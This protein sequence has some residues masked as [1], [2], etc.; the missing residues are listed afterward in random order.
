MRLKPIL[1]IFIALCI[2]VLG[3]MLPG[4][5]ARRQQR[6]SESQVLFSQIGDVELTFAQSGITCSEAL[7]I[8]SKNKEAVEIPPELASLSREKVESVAASAAEKFRD[9]GMLLS[10]PDEDRLMFAQT[11][12]FY[13]QDNRSN[14]YWIIH[15]G[16]KKNTHT[17]SMVIDDR[18]GT[19]CS[20]EYMD[21]K[22]EYEPEQMEAVLRSFCRLYLTGL[23]EEFFGFSVDALMSNAKSAQ[24]SSYLA[25]EL[26]WENDAY[27]EN[28]VTFF[29]NR[30]GF[31]TYF[32]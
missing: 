32:G 31:Y 27:G 1:A 11:L 10:S 15:Y 4:L 5:I 6:Q 23:G 19:I 25:T 13:G 28:R 2:I 3:A 16:D 7:S 20:V 30:S 29:V 9:G 26:I 18:T 14:I 17:I 22:S 24:D 21:Q 12:L 8:Y